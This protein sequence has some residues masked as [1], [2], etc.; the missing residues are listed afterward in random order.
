M[1]NGMKSIFG[2]ISILALLATTMANQLANPN[3]VEG[4][5][6]AQVADPSPTPTLEQ[7]ISILSPLVVR[8]SVGLGSGTGLILDSD[9]GIV[10]TAFHVVEDWD[11]GNSILVDL[12][13]G[14]TTSAELI[15]SDV[16]RDLAWLR[17]TSTR[18]LPDAAINSSV[19]FRTLRPGQQI[20]R[21][22]YGSVT[23]ELHGFAPVATGIISSIYRNDRVIQLDASAIPGD[24]GGPVF[25]TD[26][27]LIGIVTSKLTGQFV[28]GITYAVGYPPH[29]D[30]EFLNARAKTGRPTPTVTQ[31]QA[32]QGDWTIDRDTNDFASVVSLNTNPYGED[33][34]LSALCLDDGTRV[35]AIYFGVELDWEYASLF[36]S[37]K[38]TTISWSVDST[39]PRFEKEAEVLEGPDDLNSLALFALGQSSEM[40][41]AYRLFEDDIRYGHLLVVSVQTWQWGG[42]TVWFPIAGA[43]Y[44]ISQ[45]LCGWPQAVP[46]PTPS[47]PPDSPVDGLFSH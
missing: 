3:A 7:H 26:G 18:G 30:I 6:Y 43:G 15:Y 13:S 46:T 17:L 5:F 9:A 25:T 39:H 14:M 31:S 44:A 21:F 41:T 28:E 38:G 4:Q 33:L 19:E 12:P 11:L 32:Q 22:G 10:V 23:G 45:L 42:M 34:L 27:Q 29:V 8:V 20:L 16:E 37:D 47:V 24:S 35:F 1:S 36:G 2:A 40:D